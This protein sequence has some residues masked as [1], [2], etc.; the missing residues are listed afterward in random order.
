MRVLVTGRGGGVLIAGGD[1]VEV[2]M[3]R[4][5]IGRASCRESVWSGGVGVGRD[6]DGGGGGEV[7]GEALHFAVADQVE[8]AELGRGQRVAAF[9]VQPADGIR[10]LY[11]NGVQ[12][13]ALPLFGIDL[14]Q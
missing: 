1:A 6:A 2:E 13:C 7:E 3:R 12:T 8:P 5:E 4:I 10:G 11:V 14:R 9:I